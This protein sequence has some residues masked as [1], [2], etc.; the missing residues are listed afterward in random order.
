MYVMSSAST[1]LDASTVKL[2]S[3]RRSRSAK[4]LVLV[5]PAAA[6][7]EMPIVRS[8]RS[9]L[10]ATCQ[11][12]PGEVVAMRSRVVTGSRLRV[13]SSPPA[14]DENSARSELRCRIAIAPL[15]NGLHAIQATRL[16]A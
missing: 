15:A 10:F 11:T 4:Y 6:S 16:N 2:G 12:P 14:R 5:I 1:W 7:L 8:R 9:S 3:S 13:G